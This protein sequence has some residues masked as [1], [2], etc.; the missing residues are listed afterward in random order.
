M[1]SV[2]SV[3]YNCLDFIK[4]VSTT[5]KISRSYK[6]KKINITI[7]WRSSSCGF[8]MKK[9]QLSKQE[10][11]NTV[12]NLHLDSKLGYKFMCLIFFTIMYTRRSLLQ[13]VHRNTHN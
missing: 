6:R 2:G 1:L 9:G 3:S 10:T 8:N 13:Q 7:K 5:A 4:M 12:Q 11:A